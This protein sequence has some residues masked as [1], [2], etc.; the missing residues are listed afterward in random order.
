MVGD[1]GRRLVLASQQYPTGQ[2]RPHTGSS[3]TR[4]STIETTVPLCHACKPPA[5]LYTVP[6]QNKF[7]QIFRRVL[8]C[9]R[10]LALSARAIL[11]LWV[12]QAF[13][14]SVVLRMT[15]LSDGLWLQGRGPDR[16][17]EDATR[18]PLYVTKETGP[19]PLFPIR[20]VVRIDPGACT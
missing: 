1:V 13:P 2:A 19:S 10:Q 18:N 20:R 15:G 3:K 5:E 16:T 14:K 9:V 8:P 17:G 11:M 7:Q 4:R 6:R 12:G